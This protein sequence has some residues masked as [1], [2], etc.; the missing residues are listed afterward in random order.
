MQG[1]IFNPYLPEC[2]Y[3]PDGEAHVFG[4][5]VYVFG[6]HDKFNSFRYCAG[7]YVAYSAPINDLTNWKYEGV[8][9]KRRGVKN[10]TGYNCIWAPDVCRGYDGRYYLYFCFNWKSYVCVAVCDTPAGKYRFYGIVH[11]KDGT[12]YGKGKKDIMCFDPAVYAAEDGVYLYSGYSANENLRKMLRIKGIRNVDGTGGQVVKLGKDMLTVIEEPKMLIPGYKNSKGTGFEGHE[13]YEASS[14]RKVGEKYYF[15]YSSRLSH[16][17]AYAVSDYPDKGFVYGGEIISNGDIGLDGRKTQEALNYWGNN[18]GCIEEINGKWYI[19]YHRQTNKTEQSRQGCAEP[20][21][22]EKD[23]HI[24]QVEMTSCGLNGKPLAENGYYP[25]YI[26]CNL[27]SGQGAVKCAYGPFSKHKY[28]EHPCIT[29]E[30]KKNQTY[31]YIANMKNGAT[32]GYKYFNV[33]SPIAIRVKT[34]GAA[35]TMAVYNSLTGNKLT[36]IKLKASKKWTESVKETVILD[37]TTP[38]YFR[39]EGNGKIDFLGF[40]LSKM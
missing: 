20:I 29:Q 34:R 16:E 36:E 35:G 39:Y 14:L 17:L 5:R 1:Q 4:N 12:L 3:V 21:T 7:D 11:Y 8:I 9:Y 40:T 38:L 22:I 25:A 2:E 24:K 32:A 19:F 6:S 33:T 10:R 37:G 26:A 30:T 13:M 15:I 18:H 23:G 31:Q 28:K 27:I